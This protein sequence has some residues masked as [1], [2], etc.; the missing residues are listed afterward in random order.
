[1][2][3]LSNSTKSYLTEIFDMSSSTYREIQ[4]FNKEPVDL[5]YWHFFFLFLCMMYGE[6]E[7]GKLRN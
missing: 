5:F 7:T 4:L 1:M 6:A 3:I 2:N